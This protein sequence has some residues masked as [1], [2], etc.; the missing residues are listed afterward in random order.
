MNIKRDLIITFYIIAGSAFI[1]YSG[2]NYGL[3]RT[4]RRAQAAQALS[5]T[6]HGQAVAH[7]DAAAKLEPQ[8]RA[9]A[10]TVARADEAVKVAKQKL[11]NLPEIP[12]SSV[13]YKLSPT[14]N[15]LLIQTKISSLEAVVNTQ[16]NEIA[17]LKLQ[18]S[19]EHAS[20]LEWKSAYEQEAK[21]LEAQRMVSNSYQQAMKEASWKSGFK[22]A[23]TGIVIGYVAGR[24]QH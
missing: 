11:A 21:A 15:D 4:E 22:G 9:Q 14:P 23:L 18:V 3:R 6:A 8:A 2:V 12:D 24:I 7:A 13:G 16:D 5:D 1:F 10:D 17:Q 20:A 19:I